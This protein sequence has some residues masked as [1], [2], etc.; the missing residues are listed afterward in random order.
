MH[1]QMQMLIAADIA[2][3]FSIICPNRHHFKGIDGIQSIQVILAY[4]LP[5]SHALLLNVTTVT[6]SVGYPQAIQRNNYEP[7]GSEKKEGFSY[8][9]CLCKLN[10]RYIDTGLCACTVILHCL[11]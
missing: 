7:V 8:I 5:Y 6:C 9:G 10:S 1:G 4:S 2:T 3:I 11:L